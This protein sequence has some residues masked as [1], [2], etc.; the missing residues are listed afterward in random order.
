MSSLINPVTRELDNNL[1][2]TVLSLGDASIIIH[3]HL[4]KKKKS[5]K[6]IWKDTTDGVLNDKT[7][8]ATKKNSC[9]MVQPGTMLIGQF[10]GL[11]KLFQK[12]SYFRGELCTIF[13][14]L[15]RD[16]RENDTS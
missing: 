13:Y 10:C 1:L 3:I 14:L 15:A 4:S 7:A 11:Q 16:Q 12:P 2:I 8:D 6:L 5:D 9:N